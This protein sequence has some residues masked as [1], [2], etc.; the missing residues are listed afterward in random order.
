MKKILMLV[1]MIMML[2]VSAVCSSSNGKVL[3][4]EEGYA[5][6]LG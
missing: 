3:D 2:A 6:E 1:T 4:A 5:K